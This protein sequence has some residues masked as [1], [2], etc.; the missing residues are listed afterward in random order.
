MF[1]AAA[2]SIVQLRASLKSGIFG[3]SLL[4]KVRWVFA[5]IHRRRINTVPL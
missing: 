3:H 4:Q 5:Q 2:A 1:V